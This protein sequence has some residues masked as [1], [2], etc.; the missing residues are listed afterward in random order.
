[1]RTPPK[2]Q[3]VFHLD[4]SDA[5]LTAVAYSSIIRPVAPESLASP[6]E[7]EFNEAV[8]IGVPIL[9]FV[10]E[11]AREVGSRADHGL[12]RSYLFASTARRS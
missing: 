1:M 3:S 10:E 8:R 12:S 2:F 6:T 5:S 4:P 7:D 11:C 9:V